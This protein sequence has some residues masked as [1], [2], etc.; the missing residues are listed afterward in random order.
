ME[1]GSAVNWA[2]VGAAGVGGGGAGRS[3]GGGGGGGGTFFLQLAAN[4]ASVNAIAMTVNFRVLNMNC[5]PELFT[6]NYLPQTGVQLL[7][8][9]VNCFGA[10]PSASMDQ[11]CGDPVRV[12][13]KTKCFPSGAQLGFSLRPSLCVNCV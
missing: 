9:V 2:T 10:V 7:P 5:P 1:A 8:W 12:D 4:T 13:M 6:K 3:G 11:I